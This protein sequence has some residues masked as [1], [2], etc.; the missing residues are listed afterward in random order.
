MAACEARTVPAA[1]G[2]PTAARRTASRPRDQNLA[3]VQPVWLVLA[4][5]LARGAAGRPAVCHARA[6]SGPA[7]PVIPNTAAWRSAGSTRVTDQHQRPGIGHRASGLAPGARQ[8]PRRS[9]HAPCSRLRRHHEE[10]QAHRRARRRL[11]WVHIVGY[12]PTDTVH[13]DA[14]NQ[15]K[16][17]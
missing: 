9:W 8:P 11:R 13:V 12:L 7:W 1:R 3:C 2:R 4:A 14:A 15:P 5:N 16:G 6:V 17:E 10:A